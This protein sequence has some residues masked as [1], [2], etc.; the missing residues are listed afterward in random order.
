MARLAGLWQR[1][2]G[3]TLVL[4]LALLSLAGVPPTAGFIA[5]FA[6]FDA[7][8]QAGYPALVVLGVVTSAIAAAYYLRVLLRAAGPA[9]TDA[10]PMFGDWPLRLGMALAALAI[11]ALGLAPGWLLSFS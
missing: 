6:M 11:V 10:P 5:K 9:E 8:W 4:A 3:L 7:V 1:S 2:P